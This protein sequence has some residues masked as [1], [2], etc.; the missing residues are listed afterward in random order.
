[1]FPLL[2]APPF[3]SNLQCPV[4]HIS[5]YSKSDVFLL[6]LSYCH[7]IY[8]YEFT[9]HISCHISGTQAFH[10]YHFTFEYAFLL[11][12]SLLEHISYKENLLFIYL[13]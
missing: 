6:N 2:N 13:K 7:S 4:Y 5:R 12:F 1:M 9:Y 10:F 11:I 3:S 8:I